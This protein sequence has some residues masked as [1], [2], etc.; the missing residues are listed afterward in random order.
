MGAY[1]DPRELKLN[2]RELLEFMLTAEFPGKGELLMQMDAL[3]VVG[4]CGCGTID[5][6]VDP[7]R[8][9]AKTREPIAVEAHG[10]GLEVLLFVREGRMVSL[11]V[12]DYGDARRFVIPRLRS[13]N[14]GFHLKV[15]GSSVCPIEVSDPT[16]P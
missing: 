5:L 13:L 14:C 12:V 3:K 6:Q 10:S 8:P 9:R 16:V 1:L 15:N 4:D 2:E 11:E 7:V